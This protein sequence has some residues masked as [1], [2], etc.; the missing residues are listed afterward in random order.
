MLIDEGK[1]EDNDFY[2]VLLGVRAEN[3]VASRCG[4]AALEEQLA[5]MKSRDFKVFRRD[6]RYTSCDK[7][8]SR[9]VDVKAK[10]FAGD[11]N[12]SSHR[13]LQVDYVFTYPAD[14]SLGV[15]DNVDLVFAV[16][17]FCAGQSLKPA[18]PHLGAPYWCPPRN[19]RSFREFL[20]AK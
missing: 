5:Q 8:V 4:D 3:A 1:T 2:R 19:V 17:G 11:R 15:A 20:G 13:D 7:Q 10:W 9:R 12:L 14:T 16:E 6:F 18:Q